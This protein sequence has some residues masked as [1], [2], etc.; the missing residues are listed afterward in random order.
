[1]LGKLA[2]AAD[3]F[4]LDLACAF[5]CFNWAFEHRQHTVASSVDHVASVPDNVLCEHLAVF[6]ESAFRGLLVI[7]HQ[8]RVASHIGRENAD[9]FP[10]SGH[11]KGPCAILATA[12]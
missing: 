10:L 2:I 12:L 8:S 9:K 1:M 4:S 5:H 6:R 3:E 11:H 7:S